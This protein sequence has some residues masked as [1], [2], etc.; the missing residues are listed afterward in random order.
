MK[1]T[2]LT[3]ALLLSLIL[4]SFSVYAA[5]GDLIVNGK[6]GIGTTTPLT[7]L[8]VNG[9]ITLGDATG[10]NLRGIHLGNRGGRP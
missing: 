6:V 5:N 2:M 8:H 10:G 9:D 1:R 3:V 4:C 7:S